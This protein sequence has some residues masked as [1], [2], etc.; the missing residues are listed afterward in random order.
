M[1]APLPREA[2]AVHGAIY[3]VGHS[4]HS[5]ERF[6]E[7]L[8]AHAI[9]AIADVRSHPY[10]RFSPQF[11]LKRLSASLEDARV[12]YLFLGRELGARSD[13]P[14]VVVDG[15]VDY[16]RLAK[17]IR[18]QDGLARVVDAAANARVALM[19]A[20]RDPLECHRAILV[21]PELAARGVESQHI[22]EDGRLESRAELEARLLHAADTGGEHRTRDLFPDL[23]TDRDERVALAY[24]RRGRQIAFTVAS[25]R[26]P[27]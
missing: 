24:L 12:A 27:R 18:F 11:S 14:T 26:E 1:N 22:R 6:L 2:P 7:L 13:D 10:S 25:P 3:T 16:R 19:C 8:S 21:C 9:Q 20:E 15:K 23:S 4:N 17:T 5:I